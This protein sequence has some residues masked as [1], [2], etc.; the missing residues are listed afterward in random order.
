[1]SSNAAKR[2]GSTRIPAKRTL[3]D[4]ETQRL[5][6]SPLGEFVCDISLKSMQG[7]F[8]Q[9]KADQPHPARARQ[10]FRCSTCA[11]VRDSCKDDFCA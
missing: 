5:E 2:R 4:R 10:N 3:V 9:S 8:Y 6:N 7:A 1:M 11:I